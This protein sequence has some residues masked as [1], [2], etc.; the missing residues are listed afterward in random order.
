MAFTLP[1]FN[2][3]C[4]IFEV[5]PPTKVLRAEVECNLAYGKRGIWYLGTSFP[6]NIDS[7]FYGNVMQ[8]LLPAGTDIRDVSNGDYNDVVEVPSDSGRFYNVMGVDDAGKGFDNEH[9]IAIIIKTWGY[10]PN[11]AGLPATWPTPIP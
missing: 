11:P 6:S 1:N 2:L 4:K 5:T 10:S 3:M 8:L 7:T 9:R